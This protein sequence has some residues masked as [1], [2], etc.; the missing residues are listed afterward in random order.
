[1]GVTLRKLPFFLL[2]E[3]TVSVKC[4]PNV[5][6]LSVNCLSVY[7]KYV[8]SSYGVNAYI[9]VRLSIAFTRLKRKECNVN[10][11]SQMVKSIKKALHSL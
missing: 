5:C 9:C 6:Q 11:V 8:T 10:R 3:F 1:M 2:I 7:R 4:L